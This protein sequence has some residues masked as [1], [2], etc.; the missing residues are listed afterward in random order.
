VD[1]LILARN[2]PPHGTCG[3]LTSGCPVC[4]AALAEFEY[5]RRYWHCLAEQLGISLSAVKRQ[6]PSQSIEYTGVIIDTIAGRLYIPA[7]KL[8]KL[9]RCLKDLIA[10]ADCST[11]EALSV[12]GRVRHYAL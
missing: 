3:G 11:R 1:D 9:Q 7:K 5:L 10:A 6:D 8:E 2:V 12:R 4:S